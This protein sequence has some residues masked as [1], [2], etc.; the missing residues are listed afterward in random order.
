MA[1][2]VCQNFVST[3]YLENRISPNFI[4]ALIFTSVICHFLLIC[5]MVLHLYQTFVSAQYLANKWIEFH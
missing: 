1:L 2:D 4:Y 3:Q 5:D